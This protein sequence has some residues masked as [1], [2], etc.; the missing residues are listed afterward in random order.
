MH[1][2]ELDRNSVTHHPTTDNT[3]AIHTYYASQNHPQQN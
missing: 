1:I 3:V 2:P